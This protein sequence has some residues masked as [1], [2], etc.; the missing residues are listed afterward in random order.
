[1][2]GLAHF[3]ISKGMLFNYVVLLVFLCSQWTREMYLEAEAASHT[4]ITCQKSHL[5]RARERPAPRIS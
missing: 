3:S 5:V 2:F 1:M 4:V